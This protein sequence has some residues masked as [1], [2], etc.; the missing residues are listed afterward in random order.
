MDMT[1]EKKLNDYPDIVSLEATEEIVKQMKKS[2]C[3]ICIGK[4]KGSGFFV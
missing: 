2:I 3:K 1:E 4:K